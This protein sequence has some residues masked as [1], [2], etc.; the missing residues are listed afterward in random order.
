MDSD[1]FE[2]EIIKAQARTFVESKAYL[3]ERWD[4]AD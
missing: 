2:R 3:L 4:G 1:T